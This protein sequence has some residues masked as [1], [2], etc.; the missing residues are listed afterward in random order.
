MERN[1]LGQMDKKYDLAEKSYTHSITLRNL[2]LFMAIQRSLDDQFS[3]CTT[4]HS[5]SASTELPPLIQGQI[6]QDL[7]EMERNTPDQLDMKYD[8]AE[9]LYT[10]DTELGLSMAHRRSLELPQS[11]RRRIIYY[12]V[13]TTTIPICVFAIICCGWFHIESYLYVALAAGVLLCMLMILQRRMKK[14]SYEP[15]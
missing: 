8:L 2:E 9:K 1:T 12:V 14:R 15:N 10:S 7:L 3:L 4:A 6:F 13:L 5:I 11:K